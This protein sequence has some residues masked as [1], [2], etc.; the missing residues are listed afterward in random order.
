[1]SFRYRIVVAGLLLTLVAPVAGWA[2]QAQV[3]PDGQS[4]VSNGAS[5]L[6]L[7]MDGRT[8]D[9][10]AE[11]AVAKPYRAVE[12]H[13]ITGTFFDRFLLWLQALVQPL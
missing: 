12:A 11:A 7:T 9:R 13:A 1:M 4:L 3:N 10:T 5:D 2:L 6:T 8:A